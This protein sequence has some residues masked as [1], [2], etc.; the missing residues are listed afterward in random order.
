MFL[1]GN[2]FSFL[3]LCLSCKED[4]H[5]FIAPIAQQH[6]TLSGIQK[7]YSSDLKPTFP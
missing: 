2:I 6:N 1:L 4:A 5:M 3:S 7:S